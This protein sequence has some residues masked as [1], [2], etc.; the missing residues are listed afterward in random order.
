MDTTTK[1]FFEL[2]VFSSTKCQYKM[3]I[4]LYNIKLLTP[5]LLHGRPLLSVI[6]AALAVAYY[7]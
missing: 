2:Y 1:L 3:K 7:I 4:T 6:A 5:Y